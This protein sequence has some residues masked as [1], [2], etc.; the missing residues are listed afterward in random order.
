MLAWIMDKGNQELFGTLIAISYNHLMY[1]LK[2]LFLLDPSVTYLNHSLFGA[3]LKP[4]REEVAASYQ[5]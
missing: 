1:N 4:V 2:Q 5:I 3:T